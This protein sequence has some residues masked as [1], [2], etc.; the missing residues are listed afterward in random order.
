MQLGRGAFTEG[1]TEGFVVE[2]CAFYTCASRK[3]ESE[4]SNAQTF[5]AFGECE[6]HAPHGN[7]GRV[8]GRGEPCG[9]C[10]HDV[11]EILSGVPRAAIDE[12]GWTGTGQ[13]IVRR[14]YSVASSLEIGKTGKRLPAP[15]GSPRLIGG[16]QGGE[17][18]SLRQYVEQRNKRPCVQAHT[19]RSCLD[20]GMLSTFLSNVG[21]AGCGRGLVLRGSMEDRGRCVPRVALLSVQLFVDHPWVFSVRFMFCARRWQFAPLQ[22][23]G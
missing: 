13:L 3:T 4:R 22:L 2:P 23:P 11:T 9:H 12:V 10:T 8:G 15:Y 1:G 6:L 18:L 7:P 14:T 21:G 5:E 16:L 17:L 19:P 20:N